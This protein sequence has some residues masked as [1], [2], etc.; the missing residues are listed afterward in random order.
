MADHHYFSSEEEDS[1]AH[2]TPSKPGPNRSNST[3]QI[4]TKTTA[5][6]KKENSSS[7]FDTDEAREGA[8]QRELEGVRNINA[9]IEGV[10]GTLERAKGNMGTVSKTV[11]NAS[12]LLNT[13]TRILSQTEHNQR[14]I[15]NPNW[16]GASQDLQDIE[17]E[18]LQKQQEAERRAAELERRR[19]E[20]RRKAEEEERKRQAGT[21][22][23]TSSTRGG[24][25]RGIARGRVRGS[26]LSSRGGVTLSGYGQKSSTTGSSST[27]SSRGTSGI[28]RGGF[29]YTRGTRG[30]GVQ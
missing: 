20:A 28:G 5:G 19:E 26:S 17:N 30:R 22:T 15:L 4:P 3:K 2:Q 25:S 12:T 9:V 7:R 23:A 14:L 24:I 1:F 10:I 13:W 18:A 27:A 21:S 8:L 29:G 6:T 16:N 11:D